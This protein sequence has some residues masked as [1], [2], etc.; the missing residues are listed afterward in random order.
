MVDLAEFQKRLKHYCR[1]IEYKQHQ[2]A[3]DIGL[4]PTAFSNKLN[5]TR[6]APLSRLEIKNIITR[7]VQSQA[8][9][10]RRE[11]AELLSLMDLKETVFSPAEWQSP[12]LSQLEIS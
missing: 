11:V 8:I 1:T 12:P 7:L 3:R 2:L 5:G 6:G 10:T 4:S 9:T